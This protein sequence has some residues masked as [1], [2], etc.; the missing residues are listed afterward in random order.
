M[1]STEAGHY[2]PAPGDPTY[3]QAVAVMGVNTRGGSG[4]GGGAVER[5]LAATFSCD[6]TEQQQCAGAAGCTW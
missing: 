2:A 3:N 1:T 6:Q 4:G 5:S